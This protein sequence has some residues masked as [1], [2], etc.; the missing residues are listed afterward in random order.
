MVKSRGCS[1]RE[2]GFDFQHPPDSSPPRVI[3]VPGDLKHSSGLHGQQA[4]VWCTDKHLDSTCFLKKSV[5]D[6]GKL[7]MFIDGGK[8][9]TEREIDSNI[10]MMT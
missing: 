10:K 2:P 7:S 4:Y 1:A 6:K 9:R 5:K 3:P 8:D